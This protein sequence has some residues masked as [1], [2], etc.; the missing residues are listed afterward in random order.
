[1]VRAFL[2]LELISRFRVMVFWLQSLLGFMNDDVGLGLR[3]HKNQK[4]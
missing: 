1:M 3:G 2:R 4:K